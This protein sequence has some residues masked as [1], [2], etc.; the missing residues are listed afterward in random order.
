[1]IDVNEQKLTNLDDVRSPY[2]IIGLF[3]IHCHRQTNDMRLAY[4]VWSL[5]CELS[6][7]FAWRADFIR[8]G[9]FL[10]SVDFFLHERYD[11]YNNICTNIIE[12]MNWN[13]VIV[14][15]VKKWAIENWMWHLKSNGLCEWV[16]EVCTVQW[17]VEDNY[18]LK[19]LIVAK[20]VLENS[21]VPCVVDK[22]AGSHPHIPV[23]FFTIF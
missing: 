16:C 9:S 1:M 21:M 14:D 8:I 12:L 7:Y 18:Y 17:K 10:F 22:R 20:L 19:L 13:A 11:W 23:H 4:S 6:L 3:G 2:Q 5:K 15:G